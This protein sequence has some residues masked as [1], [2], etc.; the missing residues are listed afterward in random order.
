MTGAKGLLF[1]AENTLV[2]LYHIYGIIPAMKTVFLLDVKNALLGILSV[3]LSFCA[4]AGEVGKSTPTGFTDDFEAARAEAAKSGK[5]VLAV[6]SGNDRC[7]W[8]KVL[9]K[10][11]LSKPEFVEEAEKG[12]VLVF[13]NTSFSGYRY[14][15]LGTENTKGN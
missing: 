2:R 6:F 13:G 4:C 9:E 1:P 8:C 15:L 10:N 3:G 7:H 12:F 5:M 11:Y 14:R